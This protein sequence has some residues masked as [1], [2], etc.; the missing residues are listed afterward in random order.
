MNCRAFALGLVFLPVLLHAQGGFQTERL[1]PGKILVAAKELP[2][3]NFAQSVILLVKYDTEGAMGII[4][5]RQTEIPISE[6]L[7]M[8]AAQPVSDSVFI[9]GP[10]SR[11]GVLALLRAKAPLH[12]ATRVVSDIYFSL[13]REVFEKM[14]ADRSEPRTYRVYLG[15]SGWGAG[16]LERE[17]R[18]E[19]WHIFPGDDK[20]VFDPEPKSLW[21]RMIR[22]TELRFA[23]AAPPWISPR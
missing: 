10:V 3:P 23:S 9:G 20:V 21:R 16:Q 14:L 17:V 6:A 18:A 22:K 15:Y 11:T 7:D 1:A 4:L 13:S 2:D 19:A 5:N 12:E 8:K